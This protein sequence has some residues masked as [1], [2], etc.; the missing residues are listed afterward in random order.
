MSG[1]FDSQLLFNPF[2]LYLRNKT[3]VIAVFS[4][5]K[6]W[7]FLSILKNNWYKV[8]FRAKRG[9][10]FRK[11]CKISIKKIINYDVIK[12]LMLTPLSRFHK[13]FCVQLIV[14]ATTIKVFEEFFW[15]IIFR[16]FSHNFLKSL[17]CFESN[18][19]PLK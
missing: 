6:I 2:N 5:G 11:K 18:M 12:L 1:M 14:A 8:G 3:E 13:F 9:N 16:I 4:T 10:R 19:Y 7:I 15:E 17:F